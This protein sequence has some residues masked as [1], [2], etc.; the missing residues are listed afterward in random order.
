MHTQIATTTNVYNNKRISVVVVFAASQSIA[1]LNLAKLTR[2]RSNSALSASTK[3]NSSFGSQTGSISETFTLNVS[4]SDV[5]ANAAASS[6]DAS[7]LCSFV[8]STNK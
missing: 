2:T 5:G 4:A 7:A 6:G 8:R 3:R 1:H